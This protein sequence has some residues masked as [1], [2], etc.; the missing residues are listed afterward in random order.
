MIR[1]RS[2]LL[3]PRCKLGGCS[4]SSWL[5]EMLSSWWNGSAASA[6][7]QILAKKPKMVGKGASRV[8][9]PL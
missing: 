7:I 3:T 8:L 5:A 6:L 1:S 2:G 4:P 9:I